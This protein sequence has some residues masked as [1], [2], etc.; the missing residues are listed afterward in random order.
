MACC[1]PNRMDSIPLAEQ[2]PE[3]IKMAS[4][5]RDQECKPSVYSFNRLKFATPLTYAMGALVLLGCPGDQPW[6]SRLRCLVGCRKALVTQAAS[7][8]GIEHC[9][10]LWKA[11]NEKYHRRAVHFAIEGTP[12]S[13]WLSSATPTVGRRATALMHMVKV[14][15]HE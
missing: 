12:V 6:W 1:A 10:V 8:R 9:K 3:P 14:V 11:P 5:T 15:Q 4:L 7:R 2:V 13:W